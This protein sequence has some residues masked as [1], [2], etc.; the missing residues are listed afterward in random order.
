MKNCQKRL[1]HGFLDTMSHCVPTIIYPAGNG[2][3]QKYMPFLMS[4]PPRP[5]LRFVV[6]IFIHSS[7][8]KDIFINMDI[9]CSL[10]KGGFHALY[11]SIFISLIISVL[12][13][14][15]NFLCPLFGY[16]VLQTDFI[17]HRFFS[18]ALK[19]VKQKLK[20]YHNLFIK[21]PPKK[22]FKNKPQKLIF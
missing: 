14:V 13:C 3:S 7:I 20:S 4:H 12:L 19:L 1:S 17:C 10:W 18:F 5:A 21:I 16:K 11:I 8:H 6:S 22:A 15:I 2:Q 9:T